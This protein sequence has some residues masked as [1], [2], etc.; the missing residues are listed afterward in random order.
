MQFNPIS[1]KMLFIMLLHEYFGDYDHW[2]GIW[3]VADVCAE[4]FWHQ[5]SLSLCIGPI[6]LQDSWTIN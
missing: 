1:C 5:L 3:K 4:I 2:Y 6:S